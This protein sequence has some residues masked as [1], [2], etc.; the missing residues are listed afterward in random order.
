MTLLEEIQN[1]AV[2]SSS[3]LGTLLRKC[4]LLAARLGSQPLEDWLIWE[5]NGYP[6]D[7]E[8]PDY[9]IWPVQIRGHFEGPYGSSI[10]NASI[11]TALIPEN[12]QEAYRKYRCTQSIAGIQVLLK[13]D[14]TG[15]VVLHLNT[16]DMHLA[17]GT[18][19][20]QGY[21]CLEAWGEFTQGNLVEILNSVRNRILDFV[22][23]IGKQD[24]KAGEPDRQTTGTLNPEQVTQIFNMTTQGGT[25]NLVGMANDS[26][27]E[28]NIVA[29]DFSSLEKVLQQNGVSPDDIQELQSAL[30]SDKHSES[31]KTIGPQVSSWIAKM[32]Q[33]AG[34][35]SWDVGVGAAG[36]LLG[37]VIGK[38]FGL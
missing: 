38:F 10:R 13:G 7:V 15:R 26:K 21:T 1:D 22:L 9:R 31:N 5:S 6:E 11:P 30:A 25:V 18:K 29:G 28:F 27:V 17:L 36:N 8:I 4:K 37:Q 2:D 3:D 20:Y 16:G 34:D 19:V 24:P 33:K 14:D 23:A 35:G 32:V 12:A